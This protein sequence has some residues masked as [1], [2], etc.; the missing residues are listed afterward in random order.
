M[1]A[2]AFEKE[3]WKIKIQQ[4]EDLITRLKRDEPS[5][6]EEN[7][8]YINEKLISNEYLQQGA[9]SDTRYYDNK[10][11]VIKIFPSLEK[12]AEEDEAFSL[13]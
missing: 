3:E 11:Y 8:G 10:K 2:S 7:I 6:R 1:G 4:V 9:F 12:K 13:N 5:I